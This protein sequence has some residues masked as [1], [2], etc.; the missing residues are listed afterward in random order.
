MPFDRAKTALATLEEKLRRYLGLAG[1]IGANFEPILRPVVI[2]G[3]LREPGNSFY[4]GRHFA[5]GRSESIAA[6]NQYGTLRFEVDVIVKFSFQ[7]NVAGISTVY[8]TVPNQAGA[9]VAGTNCGTWIDRRRDV[10]DLVPLTNGAMG[11]LT[12]T[13]FSETNRVMQIDGLT[14]LPPVEGPILY[15]PAGGALNWHVQAAGFHSFNVVGRI[16]EQVG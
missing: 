13:N 7:P 16:A 12:G 10:T 11:P 2:S 6:P 14:T 15:I 8:L 4:R 1:Q 9:V 5:W 3:D